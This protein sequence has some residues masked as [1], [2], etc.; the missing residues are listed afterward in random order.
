MSTQTITAIGAGTEISGYR[1]DRHEPLP[2]LNG[3]YIELTHLGTGARHIHL[4]VP[5]DNNAFVVMLP[6]PPT[7]STGVAHILEHLALSGSER[8]PVRDAFF[9]MSPR[10]LR[11]Y[12]NASTSP[13][14]T[15][16]YYSTRN[17]KDYYNLLSI[18]LDAVFYPKLAELSFRQEG[19]RL[20]FEEPD[21]PSS[22]LRFKGVVFNEMKGAMANPVAIQFRA[23]GR[24]LFPDLTYANNAGGD[25]R[26][27]PELTWEG[28]KQFH[29]GHYH[30]S[31][32]FFYTYGNIDLKR[33]LDQ[34][35]A[36]V[37][38]RFS[39]IHPEVDIGDQPAFVQPTSL[40][41]KYPL[42]EDEDP[43]AKNHVLVAWAVNP[44]ADSFE[45]LAFE[46]LE[47]V[48]LA[49]AAS[50]L[51]K[52]LI[53][54]GLGSTLNDL[55]GYLVYAKQGVFAAGLK[56]VRSEDA[57]AVETLILDTLRNLAETGL[58]PEMVDAAIHRLELEHREVSNSGSPYGLKIFDR[59]E[60]ALMHHGDPYRALRF[61]EDLEHLNAERAEGPFFEN[62]IRRRL[63]DNPHRTRLILEPDQQLV[64]RAAEEEA[65]K[66]AELEQSL[67][68]SDKAR[69]VEQGRALAQ[70]QNQE[71]DLSVL[72][73][74]ELSDIPM[75]FED[76]DHRVEYINGARVGLFAQP[77]NGISYVD[78]RFD[79]SGLDEQLLDLLA[80]FGFALTRS[81]AGDDDFLQMAARIER[82]TGGVGASPMVRVP[83]DTS[84]QLRRTLGMSGKALARNHRA[85]VDIL[86]DILTGVTFE[87]ERLKDL[88]N[89]QRGKLEPQILQAGHALAQK[90]A[91]ACLGPFGE[92]E[93]RVNGLSVVSKLK[94]LSTLAPDQLDETL[95]QLGAIRDHLFVCGNRIDVCITAEEASLPQLR[96]L[97][98]QM[99]ETL[100]SG[101]PPAAGPAP[102]FER[103]AHQAKTT[104][105]PVAYNAMARKA[106]GYTHPDAPALMV[107]ANYLDDK[108]VLQQI[109]EKGG[110]YGAM[111]NFGR[112]SGYFSFMSYR[113]PHIVR[114]IKVF[115]D[116][117]PTLNQTDVPADDL[118]EAILSACASVDPL[119]SPDTK[120]RTRFFDDISGYTLDRREA[121]KTGLLKVTVEDIKRVANQYLTGDDYALATIAGAEKVKEA[122][123]FLGDIFETSSI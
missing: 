62:L 12:M 81:G 111:A 31:N 17:E 19:H 101:N 89:Q 95:E 26:Y 59:F 2:H 52:A 39:P 67:D 122:N 106:V 7:D 61:D 53:A 18:Y 118:K 1:V 51:R 75:T 14:A 57:G 91:L 63:L 21:N 104:S 94:K 16:Y 92:V 112:E 42:A 44:T 87:P 35:N 99:L 121:F 58:D 29:A 55:S 105:A 13:D 70:L 86:T 116:A 25:P 6:T 80:V 96:E 11:T 46:V 78:L 48:L 40:V 77:T 72:P 8:Y 34:I 30:P 103:R 47:R 68:E 110:A 90:L 102:P 76:V 38:S 119:T 115:E 93:E 66:L 33:T 43:T 5:D 4:Q 56:E 23:M 9:S 109:R 84:P 15:S 24:A 64:G 74:L 10:S 73:T 79:F 32:A 45:V 114:T 82:Y 20:E 83:A 69:I 88:I 37:L 65:A 50:P 117:V 71:Q 107:L 3:T 120:G 108:Y 123:A 36:Q 28:L 113:D 22:G 49:N 100:P 54:S 41:E 85:F 97:V 27:I 98:S 60:A